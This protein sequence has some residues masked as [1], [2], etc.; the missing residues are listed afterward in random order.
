MFSHNREWCHLP[1]LHEFWRKNSKFFF[2]QVSIQKGSSES[3]FGPTKGVPQDGFICVTPSKVFPRPHIFG[4]LSRFQ[5]HLTWTLTIQALCS[6]NQKNIKTHD[7]QTTRWHRMLYL[8]PGGEGVV[9]VKPSWGGG[10][11]TFQ[12]IHRS[13]PGRPYSSWMK[14][15][16][17]GS[18]RPGCWRHSVCSAKTRNGAI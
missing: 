5:R 14:M 2:S 11:A 10:V 7:G 6:L 18:H 16:I 15:A 4:K 8:D 13:F 12:K 1:C 9:C 3:F 17:Y